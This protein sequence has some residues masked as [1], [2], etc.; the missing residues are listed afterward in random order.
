VAVRLRAAG[1]VFAEDEA[2]LLLRTAAEAAAPDDRLEAMIERRVAGAPLELVLGWAEFG[3]LRVAVAPG[4]FI[5]RRRSEFLLRQAVA[6]ARARL[7]A[8]GGERPLV[9]VDLCCGTG[10]LGLALDTALGGPS[11]GIE[12]CAADVDPAAVECARRN[13]ATGRVFLGDLYAALPRAHRGRVDVLLANVPYVPSAEVPLLPAEAREHEPLRAL[14]GGA[15]GLDVLRRVAAEAADWLAPG[16][17]L[18]VETS[19]GQVDSALAVLAGA[20]L[21]AAHVADE[22][23]ASNVV[24]GLRP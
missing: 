13:L 16:G 10:A 8:L 17:R 4:V 14:D 12:L 6:H 18:Y 15:D 11:A 24:T 21:R 1:C 22:E 2:A 9:A 19:A 20:G 3:G 7:R 23:S 5:P